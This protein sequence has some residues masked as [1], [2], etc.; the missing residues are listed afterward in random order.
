M[1]TEL[2][3]HSFAG[4]GGHNRTSEVQKQQLHWKQIKGIQGEDDDDD[5]QI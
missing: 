5:G 1:K 2:K 4:A 3:E